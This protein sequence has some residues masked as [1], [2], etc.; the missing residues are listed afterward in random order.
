MRDNLF[1]GVK[2]ANKVSRGRLLLE[3]YDAAKM[4]EQ[5]GESL[6]HASD[7]RITAKTAQEI[8]TLAKKLGQLHAARPPRAI[9]PVRP[10]VLAAKR[11]GRS[12]HA[13]IAAVREPGDEELEEQL[14]RTRLSRSQAASD[15]W[16]ELKTL[17]LL[18]RRHERRVRALLPAGF[19]EE[20]A[21][22][23]ALLGERPAVHVDANAVRMSHRREMAEIEARL[24]EW[25]RSVRA[26]AR[27]IERARRAMG[28]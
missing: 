13:A 24:V 21:R 7:G 1:M 23:I 19:D 10:T 22:V 20:L 17:S 3:A 15:V 11:M 28:A 14:R 6:V 9:G 18:Y 5:H 2:T 25:T 4:V 16:L 26:Y 8:R 27:A 12:L